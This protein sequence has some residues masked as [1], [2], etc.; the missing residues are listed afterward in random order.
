MTKIFLSSHTCP[1]QLQSR[2]SAI[3]NKRSV[4]CDKLDN[5]FAPLQ[6][7]KSSMHHRL[8]PDTG[9]FHRPTDYESQFEW[10]HQMNH[11]IVWSLFETKWQELQ[12][13]TSTDFINN[14]IKR[15]GY[16]RNK[17]GTFG[18]FTV[19]DSAFEIYTGDVRSFRP[20]YRTCQNIWK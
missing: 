10:A 19:Y 6:R 14:D 7:W 4:I 12:I 13:S 11:F 20:S 1:N 15:N 5:E 18:L 8:A 16:I 17:S 3:V 2:D 9:M